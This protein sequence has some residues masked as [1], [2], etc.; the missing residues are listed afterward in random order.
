MGLFSFID[1]KDGSQ[2]LIRENKPSYVLVPE[3]YRTEYGDTDAPHHIGH[4]YYMGDGIFGRYDIYDLV[5]D[6]NKDSL[7]ERLGL[8]DETKTGLTDQE[9]DSITL[10]KRPRLE[11]FPSAMYDFEKEDLAKKGYTE[12]QIEELDM[13]KR[14]ENLD[15]NVRYYEASKRMLYDFLTDKLSDEEMEEKYGEEYKREVGICIAGEDK[16]N[17][18]LPY[19]IKITHDASAIYEEEVPSISD[20]YQG[21]YHNRVMEDTEKILDEMTDY[22]DIQDNYAMFQLATSDGSNIPFEIDYDG[23]AEDFATTISAYAEGLDLDLEPDV[24]E[25]LKGQLKAI[26]DKLN[27]SLQPGVGEDPEL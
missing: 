27:E 23:T 25:E 10:R 17:A 1:C 26:A 14:K 16:S 21:R 18:Q 12:A 24:T 6:W 11:N 9:F 15:R 19:P 5:A 22:C 2:I 4:D 3:E 7:Y 20:D 8:S 13:S